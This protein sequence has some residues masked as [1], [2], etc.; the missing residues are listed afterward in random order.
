MTIEVYT[1]SRTGAVSAPRATVSVPYEYEPAPESVK[2][3]LPPC[4]CPYRAGSTR[5]NATHDETE[6]SSSTTALMCAEATWFLDQASLPRHQTVK[7]FSQDFQRYLEQL[8]PQIEQ[9]TERLPEDD[10][11]AK[12]ASAAVSEACRRVGEPESAGLYGEVERVKRLARSVLALCDHYDTLTGI[13]MCL[14]CDMPIGDDKERLPYDQVS[15]SGGAA[16][17]GSGHVHACCAN[18]V[19][20]TRC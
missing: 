12:V 9:L 3:Q 20:R 17:S 11:P 6:T 16:R 14:A 5:V 15:P 19:C 1:I 7:L 4:A 18:R 13:T 2:T 8:I 10:A